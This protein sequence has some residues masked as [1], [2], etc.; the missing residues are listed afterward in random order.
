MIERHRR[1]ILLADRMNPHWIAQGLDISLAGRGI[2]G[3]RRR[4]PAPKRAVNDCIGRSGQQLFGER[5]GLREQRPG[6]VTDGE[7]FRR[8][9]PRIRDGEN[10]KHRKARDLSGMIQREAIG[11]ASA[12]IVTGDAERRMAKLPHD[13]DHVACKRT[14]GVRSMIG[15][16]GGQPLRP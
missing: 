12:A 10:I 14:L 16:D 15:I 7:F 3:S 5:L 4:S 2:E 1:A 6:P 13:L 8:A 9:L 11:H